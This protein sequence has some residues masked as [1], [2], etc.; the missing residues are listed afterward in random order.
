MRASHLDSPRVRLWTFEDL[1]KR[2]KAAA[3]VAPTAII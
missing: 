3:H 1:A 2:L